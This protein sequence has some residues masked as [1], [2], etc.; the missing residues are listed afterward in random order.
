MKNERFVRNF[1]RKQPENANSKEK[2]DFLTFEKARNLNL[3]C[4]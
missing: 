3:Y 4:P 1:V 2:A